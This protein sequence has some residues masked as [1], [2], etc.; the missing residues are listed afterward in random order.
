MLDMGIPK[1][2]TTQLTIIIEMLEDWIDSSQETLDNE[3]DKDYPN[4]ERVEKLE[5]RLE[6]LGQAIEALEGIE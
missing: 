3:S 2:R 5:A 4:Q 6:A 1:Y